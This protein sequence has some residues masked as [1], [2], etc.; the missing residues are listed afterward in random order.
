MEAAFCY[1]EL[2][3]KLTQFHKIF[4]DFD[5]AKAMQREGP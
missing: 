2:A 3:A 4:E 1:C 5:D